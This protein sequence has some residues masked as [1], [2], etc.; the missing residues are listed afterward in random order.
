[1]FWIGQEKVY[2]R[3]MRLSWWIG[4]VRIWVWGAG[5]YETRNAFE[6]LVC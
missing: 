2:V 3:F 5:V 6:D 1:M 4:E